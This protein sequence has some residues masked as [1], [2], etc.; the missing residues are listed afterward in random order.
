[1]GVMWLLWL[2]NGGQGHD[3]KPE[4]QENHRLFFCP[5]QD[6][7]ILPGHPISPLLDTNDQ[8]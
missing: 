3:P 8:T 4:H 7:G 6:E 2:A 1:M 5:A